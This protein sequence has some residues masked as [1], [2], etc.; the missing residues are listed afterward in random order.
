[1]AKGFVYVMMNPAFPDHIKVGKTT[2]SPEERAR[3]LS[4][5]TGVPTPFV[6]AYAASFLDCDQAEKYIH[7]LLEARG[8][9]RTPDREFFSTNLREVI[10]V[11]L[12]AERNLSQNAQSTGSGIDADLGQDDSQN[13][14]NPVWLD[15]FEQAEAYNYGSGD[16][17]ESKERAFVLYEQAARLGAP[18][19]YVRLGELCADRGDPDEGLRWM[20]RGAERGVV[21][22][23]AEL[24]LAYMG[25][26]I[27]FNMPQNLENAKKAWRRFFRVA[28]P[29][30]IDAQGY[31][32]HPMNDNTLFGMLRQYV[33][34]VRQGKL[35]PEDAKVIPAF[36]QRFAQILATIPAENERA[37]KLRQLREL[38]TF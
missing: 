18:E 32:C 7:S 35:D 30:P 16:T 27:Y 24:A 8:I 13:F 23:W 9:S 31:E 38:V 34:I 3:E 37:C 25:E 21:N 17:I 1:M 15:V 5:A 10:A 29:A 26:N 19:A 33:G 14:R 11:V 6:V 2:K 22:C 20:T 4:A 28:E 12:E 36:G